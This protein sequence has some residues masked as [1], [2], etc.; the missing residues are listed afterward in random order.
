M[1]NIIHEAHVPDFV[2][3]NPNL[4]PA[5]SG[6]TV[7]AGVPAESESGAV[8]PLSK[9][10]FITAYSVPFITAYGVPAGTV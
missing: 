4:I 8:V 5:E 1:P 7:E 10:P 3:N 2:K 9:V 6:E